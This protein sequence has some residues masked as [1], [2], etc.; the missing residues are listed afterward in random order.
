MT[1][2]HHRLATSYGAKSCQ[3]DDALMEHAR[4][5]VISMLE[6]GQREDLAV[7]LERQQTAVLRLPRLAGG[8][9]NPDSRRHLA[10][11]CCYGTAS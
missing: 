8:C 4:S 10:R 3:Q 1:G 6:P 9:H 2:R 7:R 11:R 5:P